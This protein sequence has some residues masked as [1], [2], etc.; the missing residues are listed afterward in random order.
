MFFLKKKKREGIFSG[1]TTVVCQNPNKPHGPDLQVVLLKKRGIFCQDDLIAD[2]GMELPQHIPS[3]YRDIFS[4]DL[5]SLVDIDCILIATSNG[6]V[7]YLDEPVCISVRSGNII[8]NRVL[9]INPEYDAAVQH[10]IPSATHLIGTFVKTNEYWRYS[11]LDLYRPERLSEFMTRLSS[12]PMTFHRFHHLLKQ[13]QGEESTA[14]ESLM[15][16][17]IL[18]LPWLSPARLVDFMNT[19]YNPKMLHL[20]GH[21]IMKDCQIAWDPLLKFPEY[22]EASLM[23]MNE[24]APWWP[25]AMDG[26]HTDQKL[27]YLLTQ[28]SL[29]P[30][31]VKMIL[32]MTPMPELLKFCENPE[33]A[34]AV[35]SSIKRDELLPLLSPKMKRQC[36]TEDLDL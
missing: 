22:R 20:H 32:S 18:T 2:I 1:K 25:K 23:M 26:Q 11:D 7:D 33:Y 10:Y 31:W 27:A 29:S 19:A 12:S 30:N 24:K 28:K 13:S 16:H 4:I 21:S 15:M 3:V 36:L 5:D 9:Q 35:Y 14:Y 8:H 34:D 6:Q 17:Q